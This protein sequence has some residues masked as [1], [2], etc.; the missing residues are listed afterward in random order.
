MDG[1]AARRLL[2]WLV[3]AVL[4]TLRFGLGQGARRS[5]QTALAGFAFAGFAV[6]GVEFLL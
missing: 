2:A 5:A 1:H 3:Y 4:V 6:V